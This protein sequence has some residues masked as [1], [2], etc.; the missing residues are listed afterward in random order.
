MFYE[1]VVSSVYCGRRFWRRC[2]HPQ[3]HPLPNLSIQRAELLESSR[4]SVWKQAAAAQICSGLHAL[5]SPRNSQSDLEREEEACKETGEPSGTHSQPEL[6]WSHHAWG[7][8]AFHSVGGHANRRSGV[9][10]PVC[11]CRPHL[12]VKHCL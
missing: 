3:I 6:A 5:A 2:C 9:V 10:W 4:A 7:F 12:G 1:L 11:P 8:D